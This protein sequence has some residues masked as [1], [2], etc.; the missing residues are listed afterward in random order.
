MFKDREEAGK[1][2]AEK[3]AAYAKK[4]AVVLALPR[5]GVVTGY[6]I[7]NTLSLPLDI[8]AV[9]KVGHPSEPEYAVGAVDES[10]ASLLNEEETELIPAALLQK[11]IAKETVEAKRRASVYRGS[12]MPADFAGKIVILA[13]DG[14]ATGLTMRLAVR[15]V[16]KQNPKRIIVAVP[17]APFEALRGLR[18][19][20]AD[21]VV[22]L[23]P[24]EA[25]EGAVGSHYLSFDQV[26]DAEVMKLLHSAHG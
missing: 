20:G 10:G 2:L 7:A 5:G 26:E 13:D 25:F 14:I 9:R 15:S 24:P 1:K 12:K 4:D 11:E 17:V 19:E 6:E 16:K 21:E 22:V 23:E 3:L 8:I 18:E